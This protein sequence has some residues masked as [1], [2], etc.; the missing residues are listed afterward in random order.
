MAELKDKNGRIPL[1]IVCGSEY[2]ASSNEAYPKGAEMQD[3]YESL[4]L[5]IACENE[6]SLY[7]PEVVK[8]LLEAY[9][10]A[11]QLHDRNGHTPLHCKLDIDNF[12]N[13]KPS[14]IIVKLLLDAYPEAAKKRDHHGWLLIHMAFLNGSP[15]DVLDVLLQAYPKIIHI[16]YR[17]GEQPLDCL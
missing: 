2:D 14:S 12:V 11:A 6:A 10:E 8:F 3:K 9:R 15:L 4:P 5:H 16:I 13:Y 1:H 7:G 17:S